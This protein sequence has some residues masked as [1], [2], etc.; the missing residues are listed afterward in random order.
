[1]DIRQKITDQIIH[2]I[3]Q[4]QAKGES[5]WDTTVKF[6]LPLNYQTKRP[7]N[8]INILTMTGEAVERGYSRN[9]WLTFK[10]AQAMGAQVNKGAKGV[11]GVFFKMLDRK[12]AKTED[13]KIPMMSPFWVFNVDEITGLPEVPEVQRHEFDPIEEAERMLAASGA[14]I[15]WQGVRAFYRPSTDSIYMPDRDR[16]S[17]AANA[18]AVAL[19]ELTHW[20]GHESRLNRDYGKMIKIDKYAFEELVAEL[21]AAY[22]VGHLGLTG[23]KLENHADYLQHYLEI[24][25]AD[26]SAIF[27]A[28]R[29]AS[30]AFDFILKLTTEPANEETTQPETL[31]A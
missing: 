12:D 30:Q 18:Y 13:D 5:M 23:A 31:A 26:K 14:A 1:M 28:A 2:L 21:G 22:L 8:G 7:Y 24:L 4:G 15:T 25:K 16:F 29:M 3:E 9:E 17:S 10:Q 20:T 27:T 19:H 6:G 11:M